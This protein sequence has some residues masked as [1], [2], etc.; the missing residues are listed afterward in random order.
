[1][2]DP[3]IDMMSQYLEG[4]LTP[5]DAASLEQHLEACD[6]CRT[7][8]A[9]LR[10]VVASA[11]ALETPEPPRDLWPDIAAAIAAA[12]Q[13]SYE[14]GPAAADMAVISLSARRKN[15]P[16][17]FSFSLP[18][19]AAAAMLLMALGGGA[20]WMVAR[21]PAAGAPVAQSETTQGTIMLSSSAPENV[22]MVAAQPVEQRYES[23]V[24]E[25]EQ[26]LAEARDSLDP[27]TVEVIERS[28][29]SIDQAIADA[30]TALG[31][32]PANPH[33]RRKLESTLEK[34][35]AL[36]SRASGVQR[37]GS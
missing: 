9:E 13:R 14:T 29:D 16:A 25:L 35:L 4:E 12:P 33:L 18:Q 26:A 19:L 36:L 15:S 31:A 32:D 22:R 7:I 37:G 23:D 24:A 10:D 27:A 20:V 6:D 21:G 8:L 2:H 30:K 34:K 17:R 1:M 28:L 11:H 5:A 3:W